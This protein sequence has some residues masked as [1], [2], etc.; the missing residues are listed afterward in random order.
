[1]TEEILQEQELAASYLAKP[2]EVG[3]VCLLYSGGL[4]DIVALGQGQI[5]ALEVE[6]GDTIHKGQ[7]IAE[8]AQPELAEQ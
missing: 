1:M 7:V 8:V 5:S 3:K 6:V 4:A 2:E